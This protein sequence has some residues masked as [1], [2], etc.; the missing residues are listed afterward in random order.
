MIRAPLPIPGI[1]LGSYPE[2]APCATPN[3][4]WVWL[5]SVVTELRPLVKKRQRQLAVRVRAVRAAHAQMHMQMHAY[6]SRAFRNELRQIRAELA[7][8][9]FASN[10]AERCCAHVLVAIRAATGIEL[11][12]NQIIAAFAVLQGELAEMP[13]GEGKTLATALA[14]ATA[15]LAGVPVHVITSNDYLAKRDAES[16]RALYALLDLSVAAIDH[17]MNRSERIAAYASSITYCSARELVFDYLRDQLLPPA[18]PPRESN[19][20]PAHTIDTPPVRRVLRGLCMGIVDEADSVLIDEAA[21]P[22]VLSESYTEPEQIAMCVLALRIARKL[23][24]GFDYRV[25]SRDS[26]VELTAN[27]R[28][29][30]AA[31][32]DPAGNPLWA[33]PRYREELT[34][35]A[36]HAEYILRRDVDYLVKDGAVHLIDANSG[37]VSAGRAWSRG[38]QQ[39][40]EL[41][42]RCAPSKAT[43][44]IAQIT[45]QRFFTRYLRLGGMS[46]TLS[47]AQRELFAVYGL[48]MR[49]IPT[50]QPS[51]LKYAPPRVFTTAAAR[52]RQ[53]VRSIADRHAT[54]QPVL[55]GTDS[56]QAS[57]HLSRLLTQHNLP[58]RLLNARQ[59]SEEAQLI[60]I[61]GQRGAI[62]VATN[63]AGRGT[64]IV[65]S[66]GMAEHGGLH[67]LSCQHNSARRIDRQL[68][69]RAARQG[70]PGSAETLLSLEEG[71]LARYVPRFMRHLLGA[72]SGVDG[73]IPALFVK[74]LVHFVQVRE[75]HRLQRARTGLR[76]RDKQQ[77]TMHFG[78]APE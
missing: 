48:A 22:F 65:L 38:L 5:R 43:R 68:F 73:A 30:I 39:M 35:I 6:P 72:M 50:A 76:W 61:A 60:A 55:V 18:A 71:L 67:V 33:I 21:T 7:R 46:G 9:G 13:T 14:A 45:F 24:A 53:V 26:T 19:D 58:H 42:E 64:D 23:Q 77:D 8:D 37:R 17:D 25:D 54:G 34:Q 15:A 29:I 32:P 31:Y 4:V 52:W 3:P 62:T 11:R 41:K 28:Q 20:A 49:T 69:G 44:V 2:Q 75:E 66:P 63:M 16:L 40:V 27:G 70:R 59:D 74:P 78:S 57:E 10:A 1:V 51:R 36:I 47:E 56:V 12:D